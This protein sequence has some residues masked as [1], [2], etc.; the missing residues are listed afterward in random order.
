LA[1]AELDNANR[2]VN[3]FKSSLKIDSRCVEAFEGLV[4]RHM[5]SKSD[6][7]AFFEELDFG[8]NEWL[9]DV[10]L[11]R[12]AADFGLDGGRPEEEDENAGEEEGRL[13]LSKAKAFERLE[14]DHGMG[15]SPEVLA[16]R[17]TTHYNAGEIATAAALCASAFRADPLCEGAVC[18]HICCL[19]DLRR[20]SEL[21]YFA[22]QLVDSR[23][24]SALSWFAVGSYYHLIGK[25]D[26][27]Q[28]HFSKASRLNPR[29]VEAWIGFGHSFAA[30]DES[31]QAMSA[32]RAAQRLYSGSHVPLLFLGMEHIKTN[33]RSLAKHFLSSA[34]GVSQD[35]LAYNE[36]GVV[37]FRQGN[38]E[39]AASC[40]WNALRLCRR[41]SS[42]RNEGSGE[43]DEESLA[44][45]VSLITDKFWE[46]T[47]NNLGHS[48]RKLRRFEEACIC[49]EHALRLSCDASTKAALAYSRHLMGDLDGAIQGYHEALA[50]KPEDAFCSELLNKALM[51]AFEEGGLDFGEDAIG[52]GELGGGGGGGGGMDESETSSLNLSNSMSRSGASGG[53]M[54]FGSPSGSEGGGLGG[55]ESSGFL[56]A[57]GESGDV[58]MN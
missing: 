52:G 35:P 51:D 13:P 16:A 28:R 26:V 9:R 10:Y 49:L 21:F 12:L 11:T 29:L 27:A 55:D 25:S 58:S 47:I 2:A 41:R 23:P 4:E 43:V 18:V 57:S 44:G 32:Y 20:A 36:L 39:E 46:P 45:L 14:T 53:G 38:W 48:L 33:N 31:D 7:L 19:V 17:A 1:Y 56:D 3:W 42:E 22:H 5:L 54:V 50:I 40:F 30:Q 15:S 34:I 37:E 6:E 8:D 24:R